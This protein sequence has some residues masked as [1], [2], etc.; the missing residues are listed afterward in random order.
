[1][2]ERVKAGLKAGILCGIAS[3]VMYFVPFLFMD[4]FL[5]FIVGGLFLFA[6]GILAVHSSKAVIKN[7]NDVIVST[8]VS[9]LVFFLCTILLLVL[10][11]ISQ[12]M[13][14][15]GEY[16]LIISGSLIIVLP[17]T[18]GI[19]VV[20]GLLY[21]KLKLGVPLIGKKVVPSGIQP[22]P[23]QTHCP[24]CRN[25]IDITWISCPYCGYD[26]RDDTRIYDD[27]TRIY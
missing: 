17:I 18:L 3:L 13:W 19:S 23:Y 11:L 12:N 1:M 5:S 27:K 15:K 14:S 21:A 25:R 2:D 26:L 8:V 7:R 22:P 24:R 10:P 4:F 6:P 9:G 20:G 16:I